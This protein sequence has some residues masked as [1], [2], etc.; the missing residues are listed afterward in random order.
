MGRKI[1]SSVS[2]SPRTFIIA[3]V[4]V[5]IAVLV[6]L[7][8]TMGIFFGDNGLFATTFQEPLAEFSSAEMLDKEVRF[9]SESHSLKVTGIP[10]GA[11]VTYS[12]QAQFTEAGTYTITATIS[13][14][15]YKTK[16]LSATL[17]I[18][19]AYTLSFDQPNGL[20]RTNFEVREGKAFDMTKL[21][22]IKVAA[23]DGYRYEWHW[24]DVDPNNITKNAVITAVLVPIEG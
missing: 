7:E 17:V 5:V 22:E 20:G 16:T 23:P 24:G 11:T 18:Y 10:R 9:N 2:I 15:G 14:E 3:V 19:K 21:P 6:T 12:P 4:I 13:M 1:G 8:L